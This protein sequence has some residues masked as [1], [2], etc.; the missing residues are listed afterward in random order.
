MSPWGPPCS[1][2][3]ELCPTQGPCGPHRARRA[4]CGEALGC[5]RLLLSCLASA[6]LGEAGSLRRFI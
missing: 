2:L 1:C 6:L 3:G 4:P 5:V